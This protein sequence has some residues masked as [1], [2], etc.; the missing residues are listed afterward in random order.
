MSYKE[1]KMGNISTITKLVDLYKNNGFN[2]TVTVEEKRTC[3]I[4]GNCT[5]NI[6]MLMADYK[7]QM[8]EEV[9]ESRALEQIIKAF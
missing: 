4:D 6:K 1:S 5:K 3:I 9:A 7:S 2:A 8:E